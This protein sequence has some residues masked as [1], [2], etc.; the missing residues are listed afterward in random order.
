MRILVCFIFAALLVTAAPHAF[1]Q[2]QRVPRVGEPFPDF[3]F[4]NVKDF[5][6]NH[7]ALKD[8][9]GK[10]LIVN[11]WSVGCTACFTSFRN[12][13]EITKVYGDKVQFLLVGKKGSGRL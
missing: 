7:A 1:S 12:I 6:K 4:S 3:E 5:K 10:W 8:F 2:S 11:F 9:Q 13:K